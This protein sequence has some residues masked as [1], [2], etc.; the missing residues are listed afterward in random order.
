MDVLAKDVHIW[1]GILTVDLDNGCS[2]SVPLK[3]FPRLCDADPEWWSNWE[4][5]GKGVGIHWRQCDE[6]ISVAGLL[7]R[8]KERLPIA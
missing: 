6:D 4:L 3:W 5:I 2:I 1:E 8:I 7:Q